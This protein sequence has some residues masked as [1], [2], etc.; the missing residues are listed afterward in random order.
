VLENGHIDSPSLL[1]ASLQRNQRAI[2]ERA[3]HEGLAPDLLWLVAELA[4]GPVAYLVQRQV[5]A[6]VA[7]HGADVDLE[8][9]DRGYCPAC[10]SWPA[11]VELLS[12]PG[13]P[14][15]DEHIGELATWDT[16]G[17]EWLRCSFCGA[18]WRL[19]S[20][21][22]IY[23]GERGEAFMSAAADLQRPRRVQLC[24]TCRCY[25][26]RIDVAEATPFELLPVEDLATNDL[27][28]AA[29]ERGYGRPSLR[30]FTHADPC[31]DSL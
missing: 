28:V 22:C 17:T 21:C 30:E 25:L 27:D 16:R 18:R 29:M 9:W 23:C 4:A 10:G 24:G 19:R 2:R 15:G 11:F 14:F 26:K 12:G 13:Q 5:M 31:I 20:A 7:A 3:L 1:M 6:A 8:Q